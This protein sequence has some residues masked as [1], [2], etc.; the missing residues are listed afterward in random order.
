[1]KSTAS[2]ALVSAALLVSAPAHAATRAKSAKPKPQ[3]TVL[4]AKPAATPAPTDSARVLKG[5]QEG[6][7][8]KSLTV[9]GEDKIQIQFERPALDLDLDPTKA[10]GLDWGTAR[11]VLDRTVPDL[12]SPLLALS[13][14][15]RSPY[16]GRPWLDRF[17]S[18]PV[19]AFHPDLKEV[20]R[21]TLVIAD[22]RGKTVASFAGKGA[23]PHD[24][25][26]DGR[27]KD[28]STVVP[29]LTYSYVLEAFDRAGNKRNFVGEGFQV[30]TYRVDT[31][32]GPVLAFSGHDLAAAESGGWSGDTPGRASAPPMLVLEAASWLNQS[33]STKQAIRVTA[34]A[35]TFE[36]ANGLAGSVARSLAPL[37]IGDPSRVQAVT[38]VQADAPAEGAVTIAPGR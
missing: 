32:Q 10:P 33:A 23:P 15:E 12:T 2:L 7:A 36:Q 29:G 35:R 19:A 13:R 3:T 17:R 20:E 21:W 22:S 14:Q 31:P 38:D 25:V 24:L 27:A 8:F 30:S 37:L 16:L 9:E 1:M 26:W 6:T 5:G 18:G 11:D 4:A 28:G 34:T